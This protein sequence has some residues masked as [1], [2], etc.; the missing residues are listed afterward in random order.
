VFLPAP[1][2]FHDPA[3]IDDRR[4]MLE[5][6]EHIQPVLR[7][8]ADLVARRSLRQPDI[9][10]PDF[11][12]ADAGIDARVL[13][14]F[15]SPGDKTVS[16]GFISVDNDDES[17]KAV[18]EARN[19]EGMQDGV[20]AWNIVPWYLGAGNLAPTQEDVRQGAMEFRALLPLF[21]R[22]EAIV[23]C[24][25]GAQA[26]WKRSVE[27]YLDAKS[28][29]VIETWNPAPRTFAQKG[30]RDEFGRAMHRAAA[31]AR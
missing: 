7:Y 24:G 27:P 16:S 18:W 5:T 11:D 28:L 29:T 4:A 17:A 21:E 22:L 15:E 31:F 13:L 23:L 25:R 8:A 3:L 30:K 10:V 6:A 9:Q 1:K 12:P 26:G 2:G 14:V 20:A 19:D